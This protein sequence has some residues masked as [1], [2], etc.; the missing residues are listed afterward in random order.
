MENARFRLS[1]AQLNLEFGVAQDRLRMDIHDAN[2]IAWVEPGSPSAIFALDVDGLRYDATSLPLRN[3][4]IKTEPA[5]IQHAIAIFNGM[6]FEVEH[7]IQVYEDSALIEQWQG[8]RA[9]GAQPLHITRLD[10]FAL[11][12]PASAYDLLHFSSDWGQEFQPV[13][14]PLMEKTILETRFGRSSKGMHPY[15][16]LL[17]A[18]GVLAGAIAW[19]GN[20]IARFEPLADAHGGWRMSGGLHDWEFSKMLMPGELIE[21]PHVILALGRSLDDTARQL[22]R[23]GRRW[24]IPHNTL[25]TALPVEWNHWW[26][27]NDVAINEAVF[28]ENVAAAAKLGVELCT[29]DAGW[30]GAPDPQNDWYST[31]GD[32]EQVNRERFPNG[33]RFVADAV[34][35]AGMKFGL[36][37]EIEGLG[38]RAA[39]NEQRPEFV[40]LLDS[41]PVGYVCFGNPDAQEWAYQTLRRLIVDYDC[42]WLKLDFNLEPGAGC[43]RTDHGHGAGDG[44]YAHVQGYYRVLDRIRADFPEVVLENC[45]SGGLRIDL[46]MLRHTHL[47]FL[48]DPDY[49]VHNLQVFW[50]ATLALPPDACLHW[51]YSEWRELHNPQQRFNPRDPNLQPHPLDFYTRTAMLGAFGFSQKLPELPTWVAKRLA[52]HARIYKQQVREFVRSADLYRLTEQPRRDGQGDRWCAFQYRLPDESAHLLFVFRL[53]GGEAERQIRLF[54]LQPERRYQIEG[55]EGETYEPMLGRDLMEQGIRFTTLREEESAL[56]RVV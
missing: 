23:A 31:R 33:I 37:C 42:D 36:W 40:A 53:P 6:G 38:K 52:E 51:S 10:S 16:A 28:L 14:A 48:S 43:N 5:G 11:D 1:T 26:S 17:C 8:V 55:F 34:H 56:V 29:L 35:A 20:W 54:E 46:G 19:S 25:S 3:F 45:A 4:Q 21:T 15:F 49:P 30:F 12:L 2:A 22:A 24:W 13:R 27:Y 32:W 50:G 44:L 9:S 7:H 18:G 41:E 47:T 39:L